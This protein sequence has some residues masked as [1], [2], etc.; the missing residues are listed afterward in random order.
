MGLGVAVGE[1]AILGAASVAAFE[2]G[3]RQEIKLRDGYC[4]Q[5]AG[6]NC[7]RKLTIHHLIPESVTRERSYMCNGI[8]NDGIYLSYKLLKRSVGG[9][10]RNWQ[11]YRD[12]IRR[13]V[14]NCD[15]A[16]T[17]CQEHHCALHADSLGAVDIKE[18]LYHPCRPSFL[19]VP[20][21]NALLV[22]A[23]EDRLLKDGFDPEALWVAITERGLE[24]MRE[25]DILHNKHRDQ[26]A[27]DL[28]YTLRW[29]DFAHQATEYSTPIKSIYG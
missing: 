24:K 18:N 9:G 8:Y 12:D 7:R 28:M 3:R 27:V 22:S 4:C 6:C 14:M 13:F 1:L 19:S 29:E 25:E 23:V 21:A 15:N 20:Y 2:Y 11:D 17:L 10:D 26:G 16:L 5:M